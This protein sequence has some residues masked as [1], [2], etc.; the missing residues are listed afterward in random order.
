MGTIPATWRVVEHQ[1]DGVFSVDSGYV[2]ER[3]DAVHLMI[4]SGRAAIV[5]TGTRDA[6]PRVMAALRSLGLEP[7]DVDWVILTHVHLDHAGGAGHLMRRLPAARLAVHPRGAPHMIDPRRLWAGTIAV[8]G[9]AEARAVHGEPVAV[10]ADRVTVLE[11][12]A[13]L[14]V[15]GRVLESFDAPGHAAHHLVLRD[16]ATG[17]LFT[18]D[19]FGISYRELDADG[20]PFVFPSST[21]TQFDPAALERTLRRLL[22]LAPPALFLTHWS[23]IGQVAQVGDALLRRLE[24]YVALA[25]AALAEAG[26]DD[27][28]LTGALEARM[29]ALLHGEARAHGCA[30]DD[31]ALGA[32]LSIDVRLNS[33]GLL[34]WLR[35]RAR[36]RADAPAPGADRPPSGA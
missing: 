2:R 35:G 21:P 32:L 34:A 28:A 30:A 25:E 16:T 13:T 19:T 3:F 29:G 7:E 11:D 20:R 18:G 6:V 1:G 14:S 31:H 22:A 12:G 27:A 23:R 24:R 9:E 17:G 33:A 15:G 5:D 8:Y 26:G 4:E 10:P 36:R